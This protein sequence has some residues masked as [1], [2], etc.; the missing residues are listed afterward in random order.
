MPKLREVPLKEEL[1]DLYQTQGLSLRGVAAY[2]QGSVPLVKKWLNHYGILANPSGVNL[3]YAPA[4]YVT[5]TP[6]LD[7]ILTGELLGDGSITWGDSLRKEASRSG[8]FSYCTAKEGYLQWLFSRLGELGLA[9]AGNITSRVTPPTTHANGLYNLRDTYSFRAKT[10]FYRELLD[11]RQRWYVNGVKHPPTDLLITATVLL[12]WFI[13]DGTLL[14]ITSSRS[15]GKGEYQ[16]SRVV[17]CTNGFTWNECEAL[18]AKLNT[19]GLPFRVQKHRQTFK[20]VASYN[21]QLHL[22]RPAENTAKFFAFIGECPQAIVRDYGYKWDWAVKRVE[23]KTQG[24][25]NITRG[26][27]V[28]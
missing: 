5:I 6:E 12:H 21:P 20:G 17:L 24:S 23:K 4:N 11:Y 26:L 3:T 25:R 14:K 8:V 19:L 28:N 15:R 27:S 9:R 1:V 10:R 2:Y 13:G 18:A 7:E 16:Y 22:P